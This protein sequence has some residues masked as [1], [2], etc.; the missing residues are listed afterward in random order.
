MFYS[1]L[2]AIIVS[3]TSFCILFIFTEMGYEIANRFHIN[4][5]KRKF[6]A[7][8]NKLRGK[9][10]LLLL[11]RVYSYL[12]LFSWLALVLSFMDFVTGVRLLTSYH[13]GV[14]HTYFGQ[15]SG[16]QGNWYFAYIF[17]GIAGAKGFLIIHEVSEAL[18]ENPIVVNRGGR[19][20]GANQ[21]KR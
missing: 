19:W 5:G 18:A 16:Q 12:F 8:L 17:F 6:F 3:Y 14:L 7:Q 2:V 21:F 13:D 10:T 1:I 11:F 20:G 15:I 4:K 9:K